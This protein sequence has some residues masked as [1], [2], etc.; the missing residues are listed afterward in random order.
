MLRCLVLRPGFDVKFVKKDGVCGFIQF[1]REIRTVSP[2]RIALKSNM[3]VTFA[4]H[5]I[6]ERASARGVTALLH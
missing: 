3:T 6:E 5:V 2:S 4:D 1:I